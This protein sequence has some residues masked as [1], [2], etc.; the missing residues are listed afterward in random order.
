MG[1]NSF[2]EWQKSQWQKSSAANV[3]KRQMENGKRHKILKEAFVLT[4]AFGTNGKKDDGKLDTANGQ[5]QTSQHPFI[6]FT[7]GPRYVN[8][9]TS[10]LAIC[11]MPKSSYSGTSIYIS[12]KEDNLPFRDFVIW[13]AQFQLVELCYPNPKPQN[14]KISPRIQVSP[15]LKG[16]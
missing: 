9:G 6:S 1:T 13:V 4:T 12:Q 3:L 7:A 11:L 10:T 2:Q 8:I 14:G 16:T 15:Y 5:R